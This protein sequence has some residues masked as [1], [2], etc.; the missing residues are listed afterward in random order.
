MPAPAITPPM[1]MPIA[2]VPVPECPKVA[3]GD[4]ALSASPGRGGLMLPSWILTWPPLILNFGTFVAGGGIGT[5]GGG[6]RVCF[7]RA[8]GCG[9]S[10]K[11]KSNMDVVGYERES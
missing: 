6:E 11:R 2:G 5:V 7:L 4:G 10:A 1:R 8:L 9:G 3:R